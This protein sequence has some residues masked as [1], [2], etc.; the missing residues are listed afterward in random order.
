MP[1]EEVL[2]GGLLGREMGVVAAGGGGF[3]GG[4]SRGV[5]GVDGAEVVARAWAGGLK[6]KGE[7]GGR[8]QGWM[9]SVVSA[10]WIGGS[11][12]KSGLGLAYAVLDGACPVASYIPRDTEDW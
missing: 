8:R 4:R 9:G 3:G 1:G 12:V 2:I 6:R 5:G 10:M 7:V 11:G